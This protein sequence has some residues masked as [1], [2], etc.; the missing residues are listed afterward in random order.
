MRYYYQRI[1]K[2][3]RTHTNGYPC[4]KDKVSF[5]KELGNVDGWRKEPDEIGQKEKKQEYKNNQM[6]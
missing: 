3:V 1:K 4:M 5:S 6:K 2:T